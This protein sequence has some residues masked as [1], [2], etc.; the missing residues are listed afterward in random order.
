[1]ISKKLLLMNKTMQPN[2]KGIKGL[3]YFMITRIYNY[4]ILLIFLQRYI[5][6]MIKLVNKTYS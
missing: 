1:V 4:Y 5:L 3:K 2:K 6:L